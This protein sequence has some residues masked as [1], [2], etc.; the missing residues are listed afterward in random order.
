MAPSGLTTL[1]RL[2]TRPSSPVVALPKKWSEA[3]HFVLP[4]AKKKRT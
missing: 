1:T 2:T 4:T 3:T